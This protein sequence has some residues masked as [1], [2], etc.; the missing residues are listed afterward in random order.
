MMGGGDFGE[1]SWTAKKKKVTKNNKC[2]SQQMLSCTKY[3]G[4]SEEKTEFT[5]NKG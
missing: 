4:Y 1:I 2:K 3:W 5:K